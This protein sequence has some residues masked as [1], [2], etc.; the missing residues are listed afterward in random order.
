[1]GLMKG[2]LHW[3]ARRLVRRTLYTV[4]LALLALLAQMAISGKAS[5]NADCPSSGTICDQG[6]AL[7]MCKAAIS[8]TVEY[9]KSAGYPS[10]YIENN[11][12]GGEP[13][14]AGWGVFTCGVRS[15]ENGSILCR[16]AGGDIN[17]QNFYYNSTCS[18][19]NSA[20]LADAALAYS[21]PPTCIAGCKAQGEPFTSSTGGVKLYGMRNRSYNGDTCEA[22]NINAN[23]INQPEERK[24]QADDETKPKESEC[25]ALGSGQTGCQK[26]NGDYC[27][28]SSTGKTFCWNP[29]EKGKK[30]DGPDGQTREEKGK[31]V[32]PPD[33]PPAPDKDW[34]RKEGHQQEACVNNTCTTYNVTNYGSAGKGNA[35]NSSGD[36][37]PDGSGNTSG[38]GTPGKGT[39]G[40][41]G[42]G[43]DED[44]DSASES[45][46]CQQPPV[47]VGDTLKCLHL[48]FTWKIE[49]NTKGNTITGGDGCSDGDVPVCAGDSCKAE[50]YAQVLQQWKQR[51]AVQAMGEGMAG[52]AGGISNPDDAGVVDGIWI[53]DGNGN[54]PKLR[55]DLVNVGGGGSL[56]P[57]VSIEGHQWEV[58]QG[59]YDAIANVRMV[60]I[61]M[62][63]VLAMF[64]VGRNI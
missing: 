7:T 50:Q 32:S 29:G 31:P 26:P 41:G 17:G 64:I 42:G 47:C 54:G 21:P 53:K 16:N 12:T 2:L 62:C 9:W 28:T 8:R 39:G 63:T 5:A 23:D 3:L 34:Q 49:C 44:G 58:P 38:N 22:Q 56:L 61:A 35:K 4:V 51:C 14:P 36:N 40:D 25:T 24:K 10:P 15:S 11:C 48:K 45:G 19:R 59:F 37:S 52:R 13:Y 30:T 43:K 55:Q 1:M 33:T 20:K 18:K 46:N 57:Q 60:I 27:A 6:I